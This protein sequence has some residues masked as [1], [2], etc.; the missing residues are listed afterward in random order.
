MGYGGNARVPPYMCRT[1]GVD[2]ASRLREAAL[3]LSVD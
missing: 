3:D 2:E 1:L